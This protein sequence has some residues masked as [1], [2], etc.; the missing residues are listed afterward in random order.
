MILTVYNMLPH[1][2]PEPFDQQ[3]RASQSVD[4]REQNL[5]RRRSVY[6]QNNLTGKI[7][8]EEEQSIGNI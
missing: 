2:V 8:P 7:W 1:D 4:K 6:R 5:A 3:R